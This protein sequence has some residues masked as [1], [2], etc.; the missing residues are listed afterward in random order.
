MCVCI[1][2]RRFHLHHPLSRI[3]LSCSLSLSL[4]VFLFLSPRH[5]NSIIFHF[6]CY[7]LS[8]KRSFNSPSFLP[9]DLASVMA[10]IAYLVLFMAMTGHSSRP[11]WLLVM[12][13]GFCLKK[14][15]KKRS[16]YL[17]WPWF[18]SIFACSCTL[19]LVQTRVESVSPPES[20]RL[21]LWSRSWLYSNPPKRCVLEPQHGARSLQLCR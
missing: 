4:S 1:R 13:L 11:L 3:L 6:S 17:N 10:L 21:C 20:Y 7:P 16:F 18:C 8:L 2:C 15:K 12:S 5:R 19:L 9:H 14:L